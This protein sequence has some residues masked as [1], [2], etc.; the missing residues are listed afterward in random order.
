MALRTVRGFRPP[1]QAIPAALPR[2][3]DRVVGQLGGRDR[4]VFNRSSVDSEDAHTSAQ[5]FM[6]DAGAARDANDADG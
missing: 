4:Q 3:R 2:R 6:I 1:Y 5:P